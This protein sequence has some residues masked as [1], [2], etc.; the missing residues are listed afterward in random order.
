MEPRTPRLET[1]AAAVAKLD[2]EFHTL[3]GKA[4][5]L[6]VDKVVR[7]FRNEWATEASTNQRGA[8]ASRIE[9]TR[10]PPSEAEVPIL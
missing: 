2:A 8:S 1:A 3:V 10:A 9:L 7:V 5:T 6:H 4:S